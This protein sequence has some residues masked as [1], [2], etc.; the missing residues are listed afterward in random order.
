MAKRLPKSKTICGRTWRIIVNND[1]Y[2][3]LGW[4]DTEPDV[5]W[6]SSRLSPAER[7]I[8]YKHEVLHAIEFTYGIELGHRLINELED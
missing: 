5:I 6:I 8:V 4:C 3:E 2:P 7:W 1:P